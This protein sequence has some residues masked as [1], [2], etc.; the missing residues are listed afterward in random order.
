M[1][2]V[3]GAR[4]AALCVSLLLL[5]CHAAV[6][7]RDAQALA[8]G[9]EEAVRNYRASS[10][11]KTTTTGGHL[12]RLQEVLDVADVGEGDPSMRQRAST[13]A[14]TASG[15]QLRGGTG[16]FDAAQSTV[17]PRVNPPPPPRA[18][19]DNDNPH[20]RKWAVLET[21]TPCELKR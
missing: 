8:L 3:G 6:D 2:R 19:G 12:S 7:E 15:S 20:K 18:G 14:A 17:Q 1:T 21:T 13:T 10:A 4:V 11:G 16:A 9:A 5:C